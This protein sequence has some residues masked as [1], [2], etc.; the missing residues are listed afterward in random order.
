MPPG[1]S[2]ESPIRVLGEYLRPVF[3]RVCTVIAALFG[4][5]EVEIAAQPVLMAGPAS[6][7][8]R[9]VPP[10]PR[11]SGSL[12]AFNQHCSCRH[13][14]TSGCRQGRTRHRCGTSCASDT[15][16]ATAITPSAEVLRLCQALL[17]SR[18]LLASITDIC[19]EGTMMF[20]FGHVHP[21]EAPHA[22]VWA[23][24]AQTTGVLI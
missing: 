2:L 23:C 7:I 13:E 5:P 3:R 6:C 10:D 17:Y 8:A 1:R 21:S 20:E 22:G 18:A 9:W 12:H 16:H 24:E 4:V 15:H 11:R 14:Q 19:M